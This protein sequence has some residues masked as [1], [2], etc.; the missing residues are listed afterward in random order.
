[1]ALS[2]GPRMGHEALALEH[3]LEL[4][5][6]ILKDTRC[7]IVVGGSSA[8]AP[9]LEPLGSRAP[10]LKGAPRDGGGEDERVGAGGG[11]VPCRVAWP[12]T[13]GRCTW[14]RRWG[15]RGGIVW[16]HL[17]GLDETPGQRPSVLYH[18]V[19]CSPC[20]LK[21]PH[22]P[23]VHD[24]V[25][26]GGSLD[27]PRP[28]CGAPKGRSA[29][30]IDAEIQCSI[31]LAPVPSRT[32]SSSDRVSWATSSWPPDWRRP[33]GPRGPG[34]GHLPDRKAVRGR[35][36]GTPRHRLV[37]TFDGP[38]RGACPTNG[39]SSRTCAPVGSTASSI[40]SGTRGPRNGLN[41]P[42]PRSGSVNRLRGRSWA[43]HRLA[44]PSTP[45]LLADDAALAKAKDKDCSRGCPSGA[46]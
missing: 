24:L 36:F 41:S 18:R 6:R 37:L 12:T 14:R 27:E 38:A 20:F 43:Y 40:S 16:F 15:R 3:W 19:P 39:P 42:G 33:P 35:V 2:R 44:F 29:R 45:G 8:E 17:A 5:D 28:S 7:S 26:G 22:R 10:G 31:E 30:T 46:P 1:V 23:K 4:R 21:N 9:A 11:A 25:D 32:S 13:R 34:Q